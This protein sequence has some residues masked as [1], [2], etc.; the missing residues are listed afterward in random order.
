MNPPTS[1]LIIGAGIAGL[2]AAIGLKSAGFEVTLLEKNHHYGGK[3]N[4]LETEGFR[5]DLGPSILTMPHL[6]R[7]LFARA[8]RSFDDYVDIQELPLQWRS[9][10]PDGEAIDLTADM[11]HINNHNDGLTPEDAEQ[12]GGYLDYGRRMYE[13]TESGYFAAG[14]EDIKG[15]IQHYGI[16]KALRGF[17]MFSSM[18]DVVTR[19]LDNPYLREIMNFFVKY[20]GSSP[21]RAPAVLNLLPYIQYAFGLWY[22]SGGMYRLADG[23]YQLADELGVTFHFEQEVISAE[24]DGSWVSHVVTADGATFTADVFLSNMEVIPFYTT[25]T[26][27]PAAFLQQYR[28]FEPSCSGYVLHLGVN[29]TYPQLAHH[30]FFFSGD[31]RMHFKSVFEDY[32]LPQDPTIYLV[33]TTRTDPDSAPPGCENIKILPHIPHVQETPFE[34][35]EYQAFEEK[36]LVKLERMGLTD[37]RQHIIYKDIWWPEDIRD[38]YNSNRG[39]IY[40]VVS[41][42]DKNRGFKAPKKSNKYDNLYFAGGSVNPGAGMPMVCLSGQLAADLIM[43]ELSNS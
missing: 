5:F 19:H 29:R 27:E 13:L 21:Y 31:S 38:T 2:S 37:L 26:E 43:E 14:L 23:L 40:G 39:S 17:D 33:A 25:I 28:A 20:V 7:Q 34:A 3:L 1:I 35:A 18:D 4:Q 24:T 22:I 10:F 12:L 6:F 32:Q 42:K 36:T 11:E 8:N 16:V 9:F 41:D 15:V 30:N